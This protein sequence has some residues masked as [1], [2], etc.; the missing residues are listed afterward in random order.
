MTNAI[1]SGSRDVSGFEAV[2]FRIS[3]NITA[4]Q[5]ERNMT[6]VLKDATGARKSVATMPWSD[7]LFR[8]LGTT[9]G[10]TPKLILNTIRIPLTA[11][12]GVDL[13]QISQVT[14][15]FNKSR[16]GSVLMTDLAFND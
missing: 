12:S 14:L 10:F 15:K 1:P 2:S 8:P 4:L 5:P 11:F 6:V 3:Q 16:P 7:A 13:T 9:G